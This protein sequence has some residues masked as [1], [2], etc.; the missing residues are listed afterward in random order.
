MEKILLQDRLEPFLK[1][2]KMDVCFNSNRQTIIRVVNVTKKSA[3]ISLHTMFLKACPD[4]LQSL[5]NFIFLRGIHQKKAK[6][7][8]KGFIEEQ[9]QMM[10]LSSKVQ[11]SEMITEGREH[12]LKNIYE[13]VNEDYFSGD[14]NLRITW[15]GRKLSR[16]KQSITCGLFDH[17]L[18]LI[19]VH[20][21]LDQPIIPKYY[22]EFIVYHEMLHFV[23]PPYRDKGGLMCMHGHEFKEK[24]KRFKNYKDVKLWEKNNPKVFFK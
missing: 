5:V 11:D 22:V 19:K 3:L 10:D 17:P 18:R 6:Q 21:Q 12:N 9:F 16:R 1:G 13:G 20:R 7:V 4:V 8:L 24:E 14:L 2:R 23:V 15:F